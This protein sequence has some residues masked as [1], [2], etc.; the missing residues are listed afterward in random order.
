M[1]EDNI[2]NEIK[3][4]LTKNNGIEI[5]VYIKLMVN[6]EEKFKVKKLNAQDNLRD[7]LQEEIEKRLNEKY[8]HDDVKYKFIENY[9]EIKN[10]YCIIEKKDFC[11]IN[12]ICELDEIKEFFKY[13]NETI[14]GFIFKYGTE[15]EYLILYQQFYSINLTN[16][17]KT[18]MGYIE[19]ISGKPQFKLVE[20]NILKFTHNIDILILNK[21]VISD[22]FKILEHN[23][24]FQN[25]IDNI[26]NNVKNEIAN[27]EM[28]E[29][30]DKVNNFFNDYEFKK[31]LVKIKG[32][33]VLKMNRE[34]ILRRVSTDNIYN[35]IIKIEN[36]KIKIESKK[37]F[38]NFMKLLNDDILIS[39]ITNTTYDTTAKTEMTE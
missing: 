39:N 15:S 24:G 36:G 9:N 13:D 5:Y 20:N 18:I 3:N 14:E 22:K 8:C 2:K 12:T 33:K 23:F 29:E 38:N 6:N 16:K 31:K 7:K 28:L 17:D 34:E 35:K 11:G 37:D 27:I 26:S 1:E 4:I 32:S 30:T 25:Y 10:E 21:Y 19:I